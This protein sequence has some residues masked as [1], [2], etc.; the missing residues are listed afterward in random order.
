MYLHFLKIARDALKVFLHT[1][2]YLTFY[3]KNMQL[4]HFSASKELF[5]TWFP[6]VLNDRRRHLKIKK[7]KFDLYVLVI[8]LRNLK[9]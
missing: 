9:L 3:K 5:V 4:Y 6:V 8:V 7:C 1:L 2:I